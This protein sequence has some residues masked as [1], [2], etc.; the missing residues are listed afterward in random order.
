MELLHAL[1]VQGRVISALTL[2]ETRSRYGNSKLGFFWALFEP[3]AHII[4]F[5]AI[6]SA[7]GRAS[8]IGEFVGLF[9]LTG[10]V[11]WLLFTNI[12]GKIMGGVSGNKALLGYPQVMPID[13]TI[14][15][16]ILEFSTMFLVM[17]FFLGIA[18]YLGISIRIASFL[19]MMSVTG[20]IVLLGIGI[21]LINA[22]IVPHYP[23]Y[24]SI[25]S[26]FVR[27]FYFISGIFFT[28]D[29]LSPEVYEM[30]D[31]N[32]LLHLI[33]WFRSGF[34]PSFDSDLYDPSYAVSVCVGIFTLGLIVER[35]SSKRARQV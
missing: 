35:M 25:Y 6:F 19:D 24:S 8:P 14:S 29:F 21:G 33:E 15:R 1:N 5:I 11:P 10:I 26:A 17:L 18:V 9:L 27:P 28:A 2:R 30:I 7:M 16:V 32:P 12:V 34:Y 13:I 3:F 4:V 31:F 20:L 22:A 23:S